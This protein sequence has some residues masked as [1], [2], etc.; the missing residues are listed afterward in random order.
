MD[1]G[2]AS[3]TA[4]VL[5]ASKG[6]GLASAQALAEEDANV[7]MVARDQERLTNAA[8]RIGAIPVVGDVTSEK[9][10]RQAVDVAVAAHGGLDVVVLNSGGP[11]PGPALAMEADHLAAAIDLLLLPVV[12]FV[13]ATLPY[14]RASDQAR[15]V[16][17]ASASVRE[18][19]PNLVLSNTVRPGVQGYLKTLSRELGPEGITVNTVAPGRLATDR[20]TEL[21]GGAPPAEELSAIPLGRFGDPRELGDVVTFLCSRQASYLTGITVP[22]DGGS[23][24]GLT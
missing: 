23:S 4:L 7:V 3:R 10:L 13:R 22:V 1:L 21:Y 8:G 17:I 12:R 19:I 2:L 20:M 15:I 6:L 11:P 18:P 5:G 14:L 9:D 24:H 16:L